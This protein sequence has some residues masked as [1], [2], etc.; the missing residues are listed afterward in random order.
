MKHILELE[1]GN[2]D[3]IYDVEDK[4]GNIYLVFELDT[5]NENIKTFDISSDWERGDT[6]MSMVEDYGILSHNG[7]NRIIQILVTPKTIKENLE[8]EIR[9]HLEPLFNLMS[10]RGGSLEDLFKGLGNIS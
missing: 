10:M 2:K 5:F 1:E 7:G 3:F 4:H 9:E 8:S 6:R